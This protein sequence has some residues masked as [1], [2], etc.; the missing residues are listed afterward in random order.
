MLF[1]HAHSSVVDQ[2]L[3]I[4]NIFLEGNP[5]V[6]VFPM[7]GISGPSS[8]IAIQLG[9]SV[10]DIISKCGVGL[11]IYQITNKKSQ[12]ERVAL[13]KDIADAQKLINNAGVSM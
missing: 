7:M 6:Y 3:G 1:L 4:C 11:L 9:Y 12:N 2:L 13:E 8:V 5:I 10:S